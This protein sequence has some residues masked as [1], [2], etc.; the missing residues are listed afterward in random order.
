MSFIL[1]NVTDKPVELGGVWL[2]PRKAYTVQT[3]DNIQGWADALAAKSISITNADLS[4]KERVE[5]A[6]LFTPNYHTGDPA[7]DGPKK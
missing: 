3:L 5:L 2:P 1:M 6:K 7:I 4:V